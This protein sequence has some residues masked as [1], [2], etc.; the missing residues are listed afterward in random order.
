M[1]VIFF[2]EEEMI[3]IVRP[4]VYALIYASKSFF[5]SGYTSKSMTL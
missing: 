3:V 2:F 5:F 4:L 1:I